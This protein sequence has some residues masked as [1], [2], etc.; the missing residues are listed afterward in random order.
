MEK[1]TSTEQHL[2]HLW[3]LIVAQTHLWS[4]IMVSD[5][6]NTPKHL[7]NVNKAELERYVEKVSLEM[8]NVPLPKDFATEAKIAISHTRSYLAANNNR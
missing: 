8:F 7:Q 4:A 2:A 6:F 1:P 3:Q 5:T